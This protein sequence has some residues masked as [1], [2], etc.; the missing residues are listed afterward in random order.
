MANV[1]IQKLGLLQ[2]INITL[3]AIGVISLLVVNIFVSYMLNEY[4]GESTEQNVVTDLKAIVAL[5]DAQYQ[6]NG[7]S[8]L[9]FI[10]T[11]DKYLELRGGIRQIDSICN[12]YGHT[13]PAWKLGEHTMQGDDNFAPTL[14]SVSNEREFTI[15]QKAP[16][17]YIRICTS[18]R[19]AD[20][21]FAMGTMIDNNSAV[22]K[23]VD[24]GEIFYDKTNILGKPYIATYKPLYINGKVAGMLFTGSEENKVLMQNRE[25]GA[26]KILGNGFALWINTENECIMRPNESWKNLPNDVWQ[27]ISGHRTSD[28]DKIN[29]K[30]DGKRYEMIYIFDNNLH[31]YISFVYPESDK[32]QGIGK[33]LWPISI[34]ISV[35]ILIILFVINI[36]TRGVIRKIGGEPDKVREIVGNI[37]KGDFRQEQNARNATGILR[38]CT[39][40][41]KDLG[42]MLKNIISGA[43]N[44][45]NLSSEV[46]NATQ[47]LS[48]NANEQA[49]TADQIVQS[50]AYIQQEISNNTHNTR[51][52]K[53]IAH[54]IADDVKNIQSA[55]NESLVSVR[56]ISEKIQIINDIAFQTNILALNAAVEAARAGEHGKGFAV[57]ASEIRKLAEKSKNSANDIIEGAANSLRATENSTEMLNS[58]VPSIQKSTDLINEIEESGNSQMNTIEQ[59]EDIIRQL[60]SSIQGNAAASE[61]LAVNAEQLNGQADSFRESTTVFK[62]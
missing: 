26:A 49:A 24:R 44:I 41:A 32:L 46:T 53:N 62:F 47:M 61:E 58:I 4:K 11:I 16:E 51:E 43:D 34:A 3:I 45:S 31:N 59:I 15:F 55:Q 23:T 1:N 5:V 28:A 12:F 22:A 57:V 6:N 30:K 37:A 29:F 2:R 48:Q 40:L 18:I 27:Q 7:T 9:L 33:V 17:G 14:A 52:A 36:I 10:N 56:G 13:L 21:S 60:N 19:N 42:N 38:S 35:I 20:G 39:D 54:S 8:N 50:V 25:F